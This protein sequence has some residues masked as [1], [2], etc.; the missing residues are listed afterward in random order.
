MGNCGSTWNQLGELY[1]PVISAPD[2]RVIVGD[3]VFYKY[4]AK[5]SVKQN[6]NSSTT[7]NETTTTKTPT[8]LNAATTQ[9]TAINT[10]EITKKPP[11]PKQ[12]KQP[13]KTAKRNRSLDSS[14][15]STIL[16]NK[17]KKINNNGD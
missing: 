16:E 14:F 12:Q 17:D 4:P 8:T 2:L 3:I 15:E 7:S 5:K 11:P 1:L 13:S 6:V 9:P 10:N